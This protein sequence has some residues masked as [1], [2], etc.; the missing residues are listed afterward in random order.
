[1][2]TGLPLDLQ[3]LAGTHFRAP[4]YSHQDPVRGIW[5]KCAKRRAH[6]PRAGQGCWW[7]GGPRPAPPPPSLPPAFPHMVLIRSG[8]RDSSQRKW[9]CTESFCERRGGGGKSKEKEVKKRGKRPETEKA[10][11]S[12][13]TP[14]PTPLPTQGCRSQL[15]HPHLGSGTSPVQRQGPSRNLSLSWTL[16]HHPLE[17]LEVASSG[18]RD[19]THP[20]SGAWK[21][22]P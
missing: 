20:S 17:K 9:L 13:E 12:P 14:A 19:S 1:M 16:P 6:G 15:R 4:R 5:A 3:L 18:Y 2:S 11:A 10:R 8:R 7:R 21:P 22:L